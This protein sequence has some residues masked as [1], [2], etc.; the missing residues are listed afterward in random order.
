MIKLLPLFLNKNKKILCVIFLFLVIG[1]LVI[2]QISY[3]DWHP[4]C[5]Q[6]LWGE[7]TPGTFRGDLCYYSSENNKAV[8]GVL[9][10]SVKWTF[11]GVI[12]AIATVIVAAFGSLAVLA[13]Q[14][15]TT[16]L[17]LSSNTSMCYTCFDNAAIANGWPPV[18]DLANMFIVLGFVII[19]IATTLRMQEYQAKKLLPKLIIVALLI[20]FS[21]LI[22]GIFI[23][24][25]NIAMLNFVKGGGYLANT[26]I[27]NVANQASAIWGNW[28]MDKA[29]DT[30]GTA[31]GIAFYDVILFI[32]FML[33]AFLFLFRYIALWIL[34]ILSPLAFVCYVFPF[35]KKYFD[36]W[37]SNFLGWCII[38][39]PGGLFMWIS[40]KIA[41]NFGTAAAGGGASGTNLL[42]YL[43]PC[44]FLMAGFLVSLQTSAMG[45][46]A[47]IGFAK[48]TGGLAQGAVAG[49]AGR[50]GRLADRATGGRLSAASERTKDR[51]AQIS[52]TL[53][54][55]TGQAAQQRQ[56]RARDAEKTAGA[57]LSAPV[58]SRDRARGE[59]MVRNGRGAVGAAAVSKANEMGQLG[60]ILGNNRDQINNRAAYAGGFGYTRK[61]F[62]DKHHF[63]SSMDPEKVAREQARLGGVN[64]ARARSSLERQGVEKNWDG[65]SAN[66]KANIDISGWHVD[67]QREF[68]MGN[69]GSGFIDAQRSNINAAL[70]GRNRTVIHGMIGASPDPTILDTSAGHHIDIALEEA[71]TRG[72][73]NAQRKY[74]EM[75]NKARG[76]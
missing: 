47:V 1:G 19:G 16:V 31:V 42:G 21:L 59:Q 54:G 14:L 66:E 15:F 46:S 11:S 72:D 41:S 56:Q 55:K 10:D 4:A 26:A 58:G 37:W 48:K 64:E 28:N 49:G 60:D 33:Y 29:G 35:T 73:V 25:S 75:R 2:P 24:G 30:I 50:V 74:R 39:I 63:L 40:D 32:V 23:D 36:M 8:L 6:W 18:R 22:C 52:E 57:L 70:R 13:S 5:W 69:R 43:V 38:G 44:F 12:L 76:V 61:N 65:M 53:G 62:E 3:A 20:N 9:N 34:V 68:V 67:D 7:A 27:G 17:G 51:I 45:A 71:G